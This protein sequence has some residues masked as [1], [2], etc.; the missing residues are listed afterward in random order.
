M[1]LAQLHL[2]IAHF[3]AK[4]ACS[5]RASHRS[6]LPSTVVS[7]KHCHEE[8][9]HMKRRR[10]LRTEEQSKE[11]TYKIQCRSKMSMA[12]SRG[13]RVKQCRA[14]TVAQWPNIPAERLHVPKKAG[15]SAK[16]SQTLRQA[17][18]TCTPPAFT[19][20]Y[21]TWSVKKERASSFCFLPEIHS[22]S[23]GTLAET[24]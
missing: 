2:Q 17:S 10:A 6:R 14:M 1:L 12:A 20:L 16:L 23:R 11:R 3:A 5:T 8:L 21:T 7:N 22:A 18:D 4:W 19:P 13:K 9:A 24:S 15:A